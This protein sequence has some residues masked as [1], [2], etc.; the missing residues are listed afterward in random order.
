MIGWVRAVSLCAG[1]ALGLASAQAAD[2]AFQRDELADAAIK[3]EAQIKSE[4]AATNKPT[5]SLRGEADA[6]FRRGDYRT[7]LQY[8]GQIASIDPADSDNWLRLAKTVLQIKGATSSEQTF[9]R[10][11][12]ATAA[13][14]AYQR[15]K[16]PGEEADALA[17]LGRAMADRSL[18]RPALDALRLSLDLREVA[19]IRGQYEKLR[20]DH[21]FRL[22]DYTVDSDS[23]S[24]R[25]CF[26]FSE[27]LAKRTDFAP[28]VA[29]AGTD[30]PALSAEE[31][32]LCVE[33]LKH[34]ERYTV[35]LRAGLPS[36]VKE[37]LAK[38][39]EFNIYVRDRKP[40]VRFTGRAYVL[41]R[42]GQRG[43]PLVS[44]NTQTVKAQVFRIG[45]RNL[46][47]T[48]VDSDFQ[49]TLNSYQLGD[50]GSERGTKVWEGELDTAAAALNADVTTA[51]PVDQV[52]GDLQPG[53]YV[54]TAAPKGPI[55]NSDDDG[56]IATQWF[57]VSDLGLTAFSGNDGI[58]VFVNS[59]ASTDPLANTEVRLIARNNEVL[60]TRKTDASGHIL[61]E[62]G[63]ARGEGG[64]SPAL[65]T[66]SRDKAD[67]AFLSLKTN[68]FDLSDRGVA[69]RAVPAGADAFVYAERGVY[70]SGETV[71]L[72]AL[73]RDGQG[74]AMTA[75]P[76]TLV[77]ERPD[78]VEYRRAVLSD[79]GAGGRSLDVALN[80]AVPTGTWRVRAFTDPKGSSVGETTFMVEDYVPDRI[81]FDI[82]TKDK[83]IKADAPVELQVDG[84]FLYGAP[85]SALQLEGDLLISPA[86]ARPGY[87]GYQFG[88]ADE[89]TTSNERTPLEN[90]P[91]TDANGAATFEVSLP[92]P[93]SS[94]RPQE[95]QVFIRMAEAG[96]RAVERKLVL[97]VAPA[98]AMIGVK[99][100]FADRNVA[101]GDVA[102]FDVAFVAPDGTSLARS[103]LRYELL[104]VE[105]R[106]QWYRQDSSWNY[107]PVKS[108]KRVADG[109]LSIKAGEP[110]RLQFN[111][112]PGRYRLDVKTA[113]AAG[114]LTSVQFDVGWYSD[115]SADTPDL[116][117]T[118]IDKPE[119][120]SGDTMTVTVNAR[121]AGLLTVNVLGDRL[122]TTQSL[123]VKPG[124]AQVK[125]AVGKDWGSGAYVVATLRRPLDS[126]AQR[127][128]G[129]A[130]GLKWFSIDKAA[131]TLTVELSP[132]ALVRPSTTLKLPVKL[133]GLSPG[134]DAKIVVAAVD[135]G[136]LNLTGYKPPAPDAYYLGQRRLSAEIR[137]LY[138]QLIDG[139]QGAVGAI[140]SGGDAS[141]AELQGSPPTQKPLA[142][143]SGIVTVAADGTAT[144]DFD[145][146]EFAG[147]A[148][149]MAVA[150]TAT[151]VGRA[152][153]DVTV[154]DPVVLT[155]TLPRFLRNGDR[156]TMAFDLDNV[157]GAPGDYTIKVSAGGPVKLSG[158]AATTL[159]LAAKQR[160][161]AKLM[162]DAGGAG[163]AT[164][165]VAIQGPN[166]L[167]LARHYA[168]DIRPA[169]QTLARRSVRTLAKGESLT[170]T[171][172][173]FSDLVPGTGGLS[174]S[175]SL[176]TALDAATILKALDRYPFG[177]SEQITSRAMPLLYVN[178]LAAGAHL[179]MDGSADE[180]I[181]GAI[182]RLLSR[183]GS[184]GSFG[185]WSTGGDDAWLDAY[186]TDFL[187]RAREK[188]F[189]VPDV[190]FRSALD[191]IRNSVVNADE[192]EKD[193]GR[194]LAYGLYVLARNGAAPIGDLRYLAD[195]K[196][197][198]LATPIAKA[199]LAAALALVGD[200]ARAERV[201]AAAADSLNPK[202]SLVF[203]RTD[204]GSALRDAAALVSLASEG[205][206]PRPTLTTAVQRVEAAR[207]LSP[208]T[209]TQENAWLVLAAR[210][211]AKET[212]ALDLNGD[213]VKTALYRSYKA[214][215]VK[216]QPL[217]IANAGD[218]PVQAVVTVSGSPVTPE[219]AA[220][221]GFKI[222][223]NYFTL[224]G[225]PADITKAKQN[226]RFA[227]VLTITEPKPEYGHVMIADYLPA[228][229]EIDNPH[230]VSSGDSGTLGWIADGAE[231]VNTEFRDDRFTAAIDR[232]ADDKA[233]FT[234]AYV[235]RAVSPGKYVLPQAVVEDMYNPSR[236][237]RTG[238]G[239]IEVRAAK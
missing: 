83:A 185:L 26:Q 159:K 105:S 70:R 58:H 230:L 155:T 193:G 204:Y 114:P 232:K 140:R 128:P 168:L 16:S 134:E 94:T 84:R 101:E 195:T 234:V 136:I 216:A 138:G 7:G 30:K 5:A 72:T 144:I 78:G 61:F 220:S 29:L 98:A 66:A 139:M 27:E 119:Y 126:A 200:R 184:N 13:Y 15:A 76:M 92:K 37:A 164:L 174:L 214:D 202:P 167:S 77:V 172:D 59:L 226:E 67:Y 178:D 187:T 113:D 107:E 99:P 100:L 222:E 239:T 199:Q 68:A 40:F 121:T 229:L 1:L 166:G 208:Y 53:V 125:L 145:I 207:G 6:A 86:E 36:T 196:L 224:G 152:N 228:G 227:V 188:R 117:E 165:D 21:G 205:S 102:K 44:V 48:V 141:A 50:L 74:V 130:I 11:R 181:K 103:G 137:D 186:V 52:L 82:S 191:R 123:Q 88:V 49:R 156:G 42:T 93:P 197:D 176:S 2:K 31:R 236:Y 106:Y 238:T 79:Q 18:W 89:E 157:E 45:D 4:A 110:A 183:Q 192:P 20:A 124:S 142:L 64:L 217:R 143:Y 169:N 170:L 175:V 54:M 71:H 80:S 104:K 122:L 91:E 148:R 221:H 63:L 179:A 41:P 87:A 109:D 9:L 171:S 201:Y 198:K 225:E 8:M 151:K 81:E 161:S 33:G 147:T 3:L 46:I 17:L 211:L 60:A 85:A 162:L 231:P 39:A 28:Y 209:S 75:S 69:G 158:E 150:W 111:P 213:A 24:P 218:N 154:R 210:A 65:L 10:E 190:A 182:D 131:R 206:A 97:P 116:L 177:C 219:P 223:R 173:V 73:L 215:E 47:N 132:P 23:A 163:T 115:G 43:I 120:A 189:V 133:G 118:S 62:A 203:G 194:D 51:F 12:A 235:V 22:L 95:A 112:E 34:G 160:G 35:N 14:I 153:T 19:D 127:M 233:V 237:G 108:T 90:L 56:Q 25:V 57:I 135:V 146:P 129:R 149:V 38:S 55:P 96:G 32:Q 180:R 212:M